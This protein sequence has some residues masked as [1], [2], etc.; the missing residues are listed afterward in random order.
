MV[1][2][3]SGASGGRELDALHGE[4]A[5]E[6]GGGGGVGSRE[7]RDECGVVGCELRL[8]EKKSRGEG[9]LFISPWKRRGMGRGIHFP[10]SSKRIVRRSGE[11]YP[12]V[13]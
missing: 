4:A 12:W 2:S 10:S 8:E 1:P 13:F 6:A 7:R 3:V 5:R 9:S 11:N